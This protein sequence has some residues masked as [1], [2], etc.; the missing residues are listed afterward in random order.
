[1][2]GAFLPSF[3]TVNIPSTIAFKVMKN[4]KVQKQRKKEKRVGMKNKNGKAPCQKRE[5]SPMPK[6]RNESESVQA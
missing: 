3:F 1:M 2:V 6:K 5:M 4:Q